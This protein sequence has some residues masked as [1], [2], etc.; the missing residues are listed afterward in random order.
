[1]DHPS[2]ITVS[3]D[4]FDAAINSYIAQGF[5]IANK[6][7]KRALLVKK[8]EFNWV[9]GVVSFLFCIIGLLIYVAI[10]KSQKDM[11]I[12]VVVSP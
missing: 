1:M 9:I 12:E 7:A 8:K 2:S 6:S 11:T 3:A 4:N 5:H 10:W